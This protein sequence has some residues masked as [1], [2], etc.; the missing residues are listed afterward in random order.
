MCYKEARDQLFP[1]D[2]RDRTSSKGLKTTAGERKK[3]EVNI[4]DNFAAARAVQGAEVQTAGGGERKNR[5]RWKHSSPKP[6]HLSRII[7]AM[8]EWPSTGS[9]PIRVI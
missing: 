9:L 4:R 5:S 6:A 8:L 1:L 2:N 3:N 7:E